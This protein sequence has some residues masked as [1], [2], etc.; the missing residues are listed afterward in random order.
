M[1]VCGEIPGGMK[2]CVVTR[3]RIEKL[4]LC[5]IFGFFGMPGGVEEFVAGYF[6]LLFRTRDGFADSAGGFTG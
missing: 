3:E 4:V 2:I 1:G 5:L 6:L